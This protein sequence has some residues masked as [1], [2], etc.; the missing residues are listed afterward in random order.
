MQSVQAGDCGAFVLTAAWHRS[1]TASVCVTFNV[2]SQVR[3]QTSV[4]CKGAIMRSSVMFHSYLVEFLR[5]AVAATI[6]IMLLTC[7]AVISNVAVECLCQWCSV[8]GCDC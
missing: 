3:M 8:A 4:I 7:A 2:A 5:T 1:N 6:C